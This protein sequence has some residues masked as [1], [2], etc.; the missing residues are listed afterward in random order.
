MRS[1]PPVMQVSKILQ[2]I[3]RETL[4]HYSEAPMHPL[5][6]LKRRP[7]STL[8]VTMLACVLQKTKTLERRSSLLE[9]WLAEELTTF[10]AREQKTCQ[11]NQ[12]ERLTALLSPLDYTC[13]YKG[14]CTHKQVRTYI[15]VPARGTSC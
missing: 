10:S 5:F 12:T 9:Q 15:S 8:S 1:S 11:I 2:V 13:S 3:L 14:M 4:H 6:Y 7:S